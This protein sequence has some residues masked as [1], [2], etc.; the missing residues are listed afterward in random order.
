MVAFT[1]DL[2]LRSDLVPQA[3]CRH[4]LLLADRLLPVATPAVLAQPAAERTTL[5]GEREMDWHHWTL[6]GGEDLQLRTQGL[7][8]SDPGLLQDA[9]SAGLGVALVSE[10]LSQPA[11]QQ[12]LLLPLSAHR[13]AGP[14]WSLLVH[15]E[16]ESSPQCRTLCHWLEQQF[17]EATIAMDEEA[18]L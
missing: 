8:F 14:R 4:Q 18:T 2:A 16:S 7:N 12:G 10:R 17:A 13:V 11:R 6:K 15:Q 5:H 9:A 3:E 1:M